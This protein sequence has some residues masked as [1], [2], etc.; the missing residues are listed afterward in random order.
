MSPARAVACQ[1]A[2]CVTVQGF[3][4]SLSAWERISLM[5]IRIKSEPSRTYHPEQRQTRI[6]C[7]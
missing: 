5:E 4:D 3:C 2:G 7:A 1:K 6:V